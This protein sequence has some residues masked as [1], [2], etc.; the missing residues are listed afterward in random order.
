MIHSLGSHEGAVKLCSPQLQPYTRNNYV[1]QKF[2]LIRQTLIYCIQ[3]SALHLKNITSCFL[4]SLGQ[5]QSAKSGE[6]CLVSLSASC[7]PLVRGWCPFGFSFPSS[8]NVMWNAEVYHS[9]AEVYYWQ[10]S[11]WLWALLT[12]ILNCSTENALERSIRIFHYCSSYSMQPSWL[13]EN[14][15]GETSQTLQMI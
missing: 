9:L 10:L 1:H 12:W 14:Y 3:N 2:T 7:F 5:D 4:L 13:E 11:Q 8:G 15:M 6:S